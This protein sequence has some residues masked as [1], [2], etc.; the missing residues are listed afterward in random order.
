[1]SQLSDERSTGA[2]TPF[3]IGVQI[4]LILLVLPCAVTPT[5]E[6]MFGEFAEMPGVLPLVTE[7]AMSPVYPLVGGF[8]VLGMLIHAWLK[9]DRLSR[10]ALLAWSA[11]MIGACWVL[12]YVFGLFA[13][14]RPL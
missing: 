13:P 8:L 14:I 9:R 7:I 11:V 4:G 3:L 12:L 1:M 5:F 6:D 2:R 10:P